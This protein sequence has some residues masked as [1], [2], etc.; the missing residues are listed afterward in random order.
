[1]AN[2]VVQQVVKK[3]HPPKS[4]DFPK[5]SFGSRGIHRSF[6]SELCQEFKWLHYDAAADAVYCNLCLCT[7]IEKR[8]LASTKHKPAFISQRSINWKDAK[9]AFAKHMG[10]ACH[11]EAVQLDK[12]SKQTGDVG[13]RLNTAQ[14]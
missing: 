11:R 2:A 12:L 14:C 7:E 6:R 3:L 10:S 4:F 9:A 1:M 8:F 5:Q 13:E